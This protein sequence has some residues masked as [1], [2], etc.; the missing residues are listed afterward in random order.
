MMVQAQTQ[1]L[2]FE[3]FLASYPEDGG[4]NE[5]IN[6]EIIKMSPIKSNHA[7]HVMKISTLLNQI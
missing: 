1:P 3:E 6:G 5:L 2:P 7:S 4:V